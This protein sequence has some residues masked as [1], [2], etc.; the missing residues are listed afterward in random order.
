MNIVATM[1]FVQRF[2]LAGR[3]TE[4]KIIRVGMVTKIIA[5]SESRMKYQI[6]T[7]SL[8]KYPLRSQAYTNGNNQRRRIET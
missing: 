7:H 8:P 3:A 1:T 5:I 6:Q 2:A 4:R